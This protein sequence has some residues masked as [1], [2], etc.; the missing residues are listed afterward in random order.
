MGAVTER[1]V[2]LEPIDNWPLT[3]L[4]RNP[5]TPVMRLFASTL[6]YVLNGPCAEAPH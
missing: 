5:Y 6:Y 2:V 1:S 4:F 3:V